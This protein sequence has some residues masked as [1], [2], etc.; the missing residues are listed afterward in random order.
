MSNKKGK[1]TILIFVVLFLL[2]VSSYFIFKS[3]FSYKSVAGSINISKDSEVPI[4]QEIDLSTNGEKHTI[5]ISGEVSGEN[6]NIKVL[7]S[8][9]NIILDENIS[10]SNIHETKDFKGKNENIKIIINAKDSIGKIN[11]AIK[12]R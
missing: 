11:Y 4:T 10:N 1:K 6:S 9:E 2:L 12:S 8:N 3:F 7:D 5:E